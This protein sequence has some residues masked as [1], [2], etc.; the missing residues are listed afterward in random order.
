M[1]EQA[2]CPAGRTAQAADSKGARTG[3]GGHTGGIRGDHD[4][5]L[6]EDGRGPIPG[7]VLASSVASW[8]SLQ[9]KSSTQCG[10][11]RQTESST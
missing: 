4:M 10:Q 6:F 9:R 11:D 3:S 8:Q 2:A 5:R 1:P 7:V